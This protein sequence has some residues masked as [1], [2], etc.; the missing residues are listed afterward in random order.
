MKR[1]LPWTFLVLVFCSAAPG[2]EILLGSFPNTPQ[3]QY[4]HRRLTQAMP[5]LPGGSWRYDLQVDSQL[6]AEAFRIDVKGKTRH[7]H[8][9]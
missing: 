6:G 7:H 4:A 1:V 9:R 5:L 2:N 8:G 3:G